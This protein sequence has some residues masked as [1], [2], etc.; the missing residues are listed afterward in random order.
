M[1]IFNSEGGYANP[2][3]SLTYRPCSS[4]VVASEQM[5]RWLVRQYVSQVALGV[6]QFYFYNFFIDGSPTIRTWQGFLEG[7]GQPRP[8][9]A[10]YAQMTWILDGAGFVRTD[11]PSGNAWIHHFNTPRGPIAVVYARTG[12][13]TELRFPNAT[14][15]WDLMG[16]PLPLPSDKKVTVTEAP[17]YILLAT[18][19]STSKLKPL[20]K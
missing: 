12:H 7:D 19:R 10:A 4:S 18:G 11:R 14:Q 20:R 8:N 16:A 6:R 17:V 1:P 15:A 3:S 2:G 5:A 9:V 13:T